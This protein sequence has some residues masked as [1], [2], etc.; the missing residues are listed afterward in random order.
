MFSIGSILNHTDDTKDAFKEP[1]P[2]PS[3]TPASSATAHTSAVISDGIITNRPL[4]GA[5]TWEQVN[6]TG[7]PAEAQ[8][9]LE[10]W[11]DISPEEALRRFYSPDF[12]AELRETIIYY[13]D[14]Y[15]SICPIFHPATFLCR[16]VSGKVEPLLLDVMRART[17]RLVTK[18]SGRKVD[19]GAIIEEINRRLLLKMDQPTFDSVRAVVIMTTLSGGE[20]RFMSYNS[21]ASLGCSMVSRLG[22]H[23]LDMRKPSESLT[24]RQWVQLEVQRRTFW[25]I[26]QMDSYQSTLCDRPLS[27]CDNRIYTAPPGSDCSWDDISIPQLLNWPTKH[28]EN[29]VEQTIINTGTLSH[30]LVDMTA[31]AV[32]YPRMNS[33][34]W[35]IRRRS[36]LGHVKSACAID[37]PGMQNSWQPLYINKSLFE[38]PEFIE[39]HNTFVQWKQRLIDVD[40]MKGLGKPLEH[41]SQFG[42]LEHRQYMLRIRY[43][44][45]HTYFVPSILLLHLAN[46]PSFFKSQSQAAD[47]P[48]GPDISNILGPNFADNTALIRMM[49]S[50]SFSSSVNDSILAY[51]VVPESWEI[52]L[53]AVDTMALFLERYDDITTE[54]YDQVMMLG[55]FMSIT[56]IIRHICKIQHP[57]YTGRY[58]ISWCVKTLKNLW[59]RLKSLG[60][61]SGAGGMELLLRKMHID[62]VM[63]AAELFSSMRL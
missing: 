10:D 46:R 25:L 32:L 63:N 26:R 14:Y 45:L 8:P 12:S 37:I 30:A 54:R 17:A 34:L 18:N 39:M 56:V 27:I 51:D 33:V 62:D 47:T 61:V 44:C 6:G 49:M 22:W 19:I 41:F 42:S 16:L 48:S 13:F 60:F 35:N 58:G 59:E 28:Q 21:L 11:E 23:T 55:L 9:F 57:P 24:W 52:C 38:C 29:R 40:A 53:D 2:S 20:A 1:S 7:D 15:Y 43:F 5:L 36:Q 4:H 50:S 3:V 31:I